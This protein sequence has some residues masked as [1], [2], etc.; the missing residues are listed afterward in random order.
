[1]SMAD[2][3]LSWH[4]KVKMRILL[5][6]DSI[7]ARKEGLDQ[8][9]I[10]WTLKEKKPDLEIDNTAV[11]GINSGALLALLGDLALKRPRA[12]QL[13]LMV[14]VNDAASHKQVPLDQGGDQNRP[15]LRAGGG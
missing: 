8:P 10:N 14:G 7:F 1:M 13:F 6:G 11:S 12:D 9:R 3:M 2:L 4:R 15:G 5:L